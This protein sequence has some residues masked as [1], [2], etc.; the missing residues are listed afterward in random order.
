[1]KSKGS[2]HLDVGPLYKVLPYVYANVPTPKEI[3]KFWSQALQ[4]RDTQVIPQ[5]LRI[6][7]TFPKFLHLPPSHPCRHPSVTLLESH[8]YQLNVS[9]SSKFICGNPKPKVMILGDGTLGRY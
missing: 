6:W 1:M 8:C 9:A 7:V 5:I 2:L 3:P 4:L